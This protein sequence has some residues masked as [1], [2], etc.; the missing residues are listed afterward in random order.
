MGANSAQRS[1]RRQILSGLLPPTIALAAVAAEPAVVVWGRGRDSVLPLLVFGVL[2]AILHP[3]VR[4]MLLVTLCYG[5]AFLSVRDTFRMPA[6]AL[7]Q[8]LDNDLLDVV[9]PVALLTV[10]VLAATAGIVETLS[11]GTVWARR[12]YFGAAAL[13]FCGSGVLSYLWQP[14]WQAVLLIAI[15]VMALIGVILADRVVASELEDDE[16]MPVSDEAIQQL[17]EAAHRRVLTAKEWHDSP[18]T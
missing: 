16:P 1:L 9:R 4:Q 11:P 8:S 6:I 14:S 3:I 7:P 13:Y 2:A 18:L 12:C 15:G 17:S 10:A 5:V